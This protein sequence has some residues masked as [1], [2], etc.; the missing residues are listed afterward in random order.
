MRR[1]AECRR[2]VNFSERPSTHRM[3]AAE[4][5]QTPRA[6]AFMMLHVRLRSH[7]SG[8]LEYAASDTFQCVYPP[9]LEHCC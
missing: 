5:T 7:W 1:R 2:L 3:A 8:V 4:H 6:D 9:V